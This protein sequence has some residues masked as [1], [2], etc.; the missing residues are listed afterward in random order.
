VAARAPGGAPGAPVDGA[1]GRGARAAL[2]A[3][4]DLAV[5]W[6]AAKREQAMSGQL[7]L[8]GDAEVLPPALQPPGDFSELEM[9]RYEKEA[10][11]IY[12]SAH[13]MASYPG[14]AEAATC[15]VAEVDACFARAR[16]DGAP[17]R[18]R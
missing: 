4:V 7:G 11:G 13:P 17:G 8:F 3:N 6:G 12:L 10:L 15:P 1:A 9:L 16:A 2:L 18:V 5:K 14:L